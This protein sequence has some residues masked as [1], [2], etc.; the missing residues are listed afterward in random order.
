MLYFVAIPYAYDIAVAVAGDQ[1]YKPVLQHVRR[2]GKRVAIS[3]IKGS[4]APDYADPR[5]EVRVKDFDVVWI[6]NLLHKLELRYEK[7]Q[8]ECGSPFHKGERRVWCLP[9]AT[10]FSARTALAPC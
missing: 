6:D 7:H 4:C 5:D 8:L 3:S 9:S 2:L 1:D 10:G